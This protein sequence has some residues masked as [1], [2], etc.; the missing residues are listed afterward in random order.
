MAGVQLQLTA[1]ARGT[2][3]SCRRSPGRHDGRIGHR[4][5]DPWTCRHGGGDERRLSLRR[6]AHSRRFRRWKAARSERAAH[7]LADEAMGRLAPL[8]KELAWTLRWAPE[9]LA[10]KP[11]LMR[12]R[13]RFRSRE[14]SVLSHLSQTLTL[15]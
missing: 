2:G 8:L 6:A 12:L 14:D 1:M 11:V 7:A 3:P 5:F 4:A 9:A 15:R 13:P 10:G